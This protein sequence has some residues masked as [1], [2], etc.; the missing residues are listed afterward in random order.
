MGLVFDSES[1]EAEEDL[2]DSL[3]GASDGERKMVTD[4]FDNAFFGLDD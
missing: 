3:F 4:E 2:F 1:W